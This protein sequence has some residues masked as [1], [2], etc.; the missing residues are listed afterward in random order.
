MEAYEIRN[1][2][3]RTIS[4]LVLV[5]SLLLISAL[6]YIGIKTY[7]R[8]QELHTTMEQI[9][10]SNEEDSIVSNDYIYFDYLEQDN[11]INTLDDGEVVAHFPNTK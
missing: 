8:N 1:K 4:Y 6:S 2:R 10:E 9:I 5:F 11:T 3:I 7:F